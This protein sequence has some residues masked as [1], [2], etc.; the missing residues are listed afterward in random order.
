MA[1]SGDTVKAGSHTGL[2]RSLSCMHRLRH[3]NRRAL[4]L[5]PRCD[6][7]GRLDPDLKTVRF[8]ERPRFDILQG[9]EVGRRTASLALAL[10]LPLEALRI[11]R[12]LRRTRHAIGSTDPLPL[13]LGPSRLPSPLASA[14]SFG[15]MSDRAKRKKGRGT[16]CWT[17]TLPVVRPTRRGNGND[18]DAI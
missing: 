1:I 7:T 17:T 2:V 18:V 16:D 6:V 10:A 5:E 9:G 8:D 15:N 12:G 14:P 4:A 13:T 11:R 3:R